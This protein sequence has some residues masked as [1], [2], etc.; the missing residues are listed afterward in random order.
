MAYLGVPL[1]M[2]ITRTV[3]GADRALGDI[4]TIRNDA[5]PTSIFI[6]SPAFSMGSHSIA[7][8]LSTLT[9]LAVEPQIHGCVAH[10]QH[11]SSTAFS[12]QAV[13]NNFW[14]P[15][16]CELRVHIV[17]ERLIVVG[18]SMPRLLFAF[19]GFN[20]REAVTIAWPKGATIAWQLARYGIV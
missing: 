2:A 18:M 11:V 9:G 12:G 6:L 14:R 3:I 7:G 17:A 1:P 19:V 15:A 5:T 13:G 20:L 8:H 4:K 16:E 10:S